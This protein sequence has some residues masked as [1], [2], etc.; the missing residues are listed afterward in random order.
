[1]QEGLSVFL[2]HVGLLII[3]VSLKLEK[4]IT[5]HI[6]LCFDEKIKFYS[7]Y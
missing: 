4:S 7:L 3:P 2:K 5:K 1:M 6:G